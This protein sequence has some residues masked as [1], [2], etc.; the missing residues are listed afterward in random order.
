MS[1]CFVCHYPGVVTIPALEGEVEMCN[2]CLSFLT[3]QIR[4]MIC[5]GFLNEARAIIAGLRLRDAQATVLFLR[6]NAH[7]EAAAEARRLFGEHTAEATRRFNE[8]IAAM[9][10]QIARAVAQ[11]DGERLRADRAERRAAAAERREAEAKRDAENLLRRLTIIRL[12]L[13]VDPVDFDRQ[14]RVSVPAQGPASTI[15]GWEYVAH[16]FPDG[17]YQ[18]NEQAH[19]RIK[20]GLYSLLNIAGNQATAAGRRT[21]MA[22]ARIINKKSQIFRWPSLDGTGGFMVFDAW[23]LAVAQGLKDNDMLSVYGFGPAMLT[24]IKAMAQEYVQL[25]PK[26]GED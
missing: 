22:L 12:A 14:A 3:A 26:Q 21:V 24:T 20:D 25:L 5:K 6:E 9:T 23:A 18:D 1:D 17:T 4:V 8:R 11:A 7:N 19:D 15:D 2:P 16:C 13:N 10:E